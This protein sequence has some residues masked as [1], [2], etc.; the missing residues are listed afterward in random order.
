MNESVWIMQ[1]RDLGKVLK[2]QHEQDTVK[3]F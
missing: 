1:H 2:K 3:E